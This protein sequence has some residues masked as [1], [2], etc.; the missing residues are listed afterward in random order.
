M[1]KAIFCPLKGHLLQDKTRPFA[2]PLITSH[3]QSRHKPPY[4]KAFV[5]QLCE[6]SEPATTN[7]RNH[8]KTIYESLL[9]Y[10]ILPNTYKPYKTNVFNSLATAGSFNSFNFFNSQ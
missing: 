1:Q 9:S 10:L 2:T 4:S 8:R 3:L 5:R 6:R 7:S